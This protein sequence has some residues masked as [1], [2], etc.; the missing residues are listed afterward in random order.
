MAR[1][2]GRQRGRWRKG[3]ARGGGR[4]GRGR[5]H[6]RAGV[7]KV[8]GDR[9]GT[10]EQ[11][12]YLRGEGRPGICLPRRASVFLVPP[13]TAAF[14]YVSTNK[15]PHRLRAALE[16]S[17]ASPQSLSHRR[18]LENDIR[19]GSFFSRGLTPSNTRQRRVSGRAPPTSLFPSSVFFKIARVFVP[20][21][22]RP[23]R[24]HS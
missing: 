2:R 18:M 21:A 24:C 16:D 6:R 15:L 3:T 13:C 12:L 9:G 20:S 5:G 23:G 19:P 1:G 11:H 4:G 7:P 10:P 17:G 14:L 8:P 22:R